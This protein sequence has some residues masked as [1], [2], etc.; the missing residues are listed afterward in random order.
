M[1]VDVGCLN[2]ILT[3]NLRGLGPDTIFLFCRPSFFFALIFFF[4]HLVLDVALNK[5]EGVRPLGQDDGLEKEFPFT[6]LGFVGV[7]GVH[8]IFFR[9]TNCKTKLTFSSKFELLIFYNIWRSRSQMI[10]G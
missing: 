1:F 6:F 10:A 4:V 9:C 8:V 2:F 5:L 7:I 3:L